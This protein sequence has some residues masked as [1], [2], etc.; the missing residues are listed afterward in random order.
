MYYPVSE[1]A[2]FLH[3]TPLAVPW[4]NRR[5]TERNR[6]NPRLKDGLVQLLLQKILK[7]GTMAA[8]MRSSIFSNSHLRTSIGSTFTR[9]EKGA[10]QAA[11]SRPQNAR[12]LRR[13]C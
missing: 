1:V 4:S 6:L 3:V 13:R 5:F 11:S 7:T 9:N 2:R 10:E 12:L 8:V